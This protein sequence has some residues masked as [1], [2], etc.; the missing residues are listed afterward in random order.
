MTETKK[1]SRTLLKV[2]ITGG[3]GTGKTMACRLF[4]TLGVPVYYADDRAKWLMQYQETVR[5][6]LIDAFGAAVYQADGALDREYLAGL[7]FN[8][9]AQLQRLNAIVHPAVYRDG[10]EWQAAQ[11]EKGVLYTLKEAA[12]LYETGSYAQLDKIIVVTAPEA[13]RIARVMARDGATEEQVRARMSKQLPQAEKE[14]RADFLLHNTTKE[15]LAE[16]VER[17]HQRLCTLAQALQ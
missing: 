16:Q 1:N 17:L 15:A 3:I 7:V 12:L 8:N 11:A 9:E 4:E 14:A 10:E 6:Q 5:D 13:T 2:G